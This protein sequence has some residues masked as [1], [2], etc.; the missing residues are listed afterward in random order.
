M[1]NSSIIRWLNQLINDMDSPQ[2]GSCPAK[3]CCKSALARQVDA[4]H[5]RFAD[6]KVMADELLDKVKLADESECR[7]VEG[8][9]PGVAVNLN[10]SPSNSQILLAGDLG[11]EDFNADC[12]TCLTACDR[13]VKDAASLKAALG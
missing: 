7:A 8:R 1:T 6:V 2:V 10:R 9:V 3:G 4:N 13:T 11:I 12:S 5:Q